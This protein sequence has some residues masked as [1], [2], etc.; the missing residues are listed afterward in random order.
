M[1]ETTLDLQLLITDQFMNCVI[2][3]SP[4][5][6]RILDMQEMFDIQEAFQFNFF[7]QKAIY[8]SVIGTIF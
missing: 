2:T 3:I 4:I 1:K 8:K 6:A 5:R 7:R